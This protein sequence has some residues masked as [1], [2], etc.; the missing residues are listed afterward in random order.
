MPKVLRALTALAICAATGL[1]SAAVAASPEKHRVNTTPEILVLN[2]APEGDAPAK[3][4]PVTGAEATVR[5][6]RTFLDTFS[7]FTPN[8]PPWQHRADYGPPD[9]YWNRTLPSNSEQQLY[10]DPAYPGTGK[11][12]LRLNPFAVRDGVLEITGQKAP[13]AALPQLDGYRYV[14][15]MLSSVVSFEQKYGFFEARLRLPG[16]QGVWPAFWLLRGSRHVPEG[17]SFWPPEIDIMEHIGAPDHYHVTTHWDVSPNNKRSGMEISVEDPT[18]R[19]HNYGVLW[20]PERTVFY[21]DRQPVAQIETK[22][23]HHVE[24]FI[25][26]NLALGG[27]WPGPISEAALPATYEID[28][29]SAW[30]FEGE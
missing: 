6:R 23:N 29:V 11:R 7:S 28:W 22:P 20:G 5:L 24:M 13:A 18:R 21:L 1:S 26:I 15:G 12:P 3:M 16:G 17:T 30:Q 2:T 27:S 4:T 25:F 14:S 8:T 9:V 10:V 19:F